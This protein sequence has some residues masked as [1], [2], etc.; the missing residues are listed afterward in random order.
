MNQRL[1]FERMAF[2]GAL[3]LG[4]AGCGATSIDDPG[5][6][7]G[8]VRGDAASKRDFLA[9]FPTDWGCEQ[10]DALERYIVYLSCDSRRAGY[11][12]WRNADAMESNREELQQSDDQMSD[13]VVHAG[14]T[15]ALAS[16]WAEV[17]GAP[18]WDAA[19]RLIIES[20]DGPTETFGTRCP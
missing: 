7:L 10:F 20:F 5:A 13:C 2:V 14:S 6:S 1:R 3:L 11:F 19:T 18:N 4:I 12:Y 15:F 16:R 9:S 8:P 17:K